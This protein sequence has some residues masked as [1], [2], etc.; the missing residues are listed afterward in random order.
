M[1]PISQAIAINVDITAPLLQIIPFYARTQSDPDN[2]II[3]I[4]K[5]IFNAGKAKSDLAQ[6]QGK[7]YPGYR[8]KKFS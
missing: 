1:F 6:Y 2:G 5:G 3:I 8:Q 4:K 7:D